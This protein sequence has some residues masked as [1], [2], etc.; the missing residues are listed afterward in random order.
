MDIL[1]QYKKTLL[2]RFFEEKV[3]RLFSRG[4]LG[5]TTHLCIGQ[6][7]VAVGVISQLRRED[8]VVSTHRGHG[9]MIAKGADIQKIFAELLGRREGYCRGRGGTQHLCAMD[10]NFLGTNGITGGG[11]PIATGAGLKIKVTGEDRIV[12]CFFGDGA[13]NQGTFHESLN[14]ASVW[15]LPVLYVCEN[16]L[17]GMSTRFS[18]VSATEAV[19]QRA[20]SYGIPSIIADGMDTLAMAQTTRKV[21][22][23]VRKGRG[24]FLIEAR[25]YRFCGHS[26]SDPR[27]YRTRAEEEEWKKRD[28]LAKL[29][30]TLQASVPEGEM[31]ALKEDLKK[32]VD[33]AF[34]RAERETTAPDLEDTLGGVYAQRKDILQEGRIQGPRRGARPR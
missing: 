18:D 5:G 29:E 16:N 28:P 30:D 26:K 22:E 1:E 3:D 10:I 34:I 14:M 9:H 8:Y 20:R 32:R 27:T 13:A 7:A 31:E 33:D 17:Y 12:V 11:I 23:R 6:E 21:I 25:T 19:A 2:I 15:R 4:R 24:P